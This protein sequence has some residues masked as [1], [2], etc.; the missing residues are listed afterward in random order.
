MRK[1]P[2]VIALR[3][4]IEALKA[5]GM[6]LL[7]TQRGIKG[8]MESA[9]KRIAEFERRVRQLQVLLETGDARMVD[10]ERERQVVW[11]KI[12]TLEAELA[13]LES[14]G[15]V[16]KGVT[17]TKAATRAALITR[18]GAGDQSVIPALV[19]LETLDWAEWVERWGR[20]VGEMESD[21]VGV[22]K[23]RFQ[24]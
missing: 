10:L 15:R 8:S 12:R 1:S 14:A 20:S 23:A 9:P 24:K 5:E 7:E 3:E 6:M 22:Y 2:K 16:T 18:L 4:M 17:P 19:A 13:G 11:G 21:S